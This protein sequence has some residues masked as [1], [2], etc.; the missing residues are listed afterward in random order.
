V[1]R[2]VIV[3]VALL[4]IAVVLAGLNQAPSTNANTTSNAHSTTGSI[5]T[6]SP[7]APAWVM[8]DAIEKIDLDVNRWAKS[9]YGVVEVTFIINNKS[10]YDVKD[11]GLRCNYYAPSGTKVSST[12]WGVYEIFKARTKRTIKVAR[13]GI[14]NTQAKS[15]GC[16][17]YALKKA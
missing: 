16:S 11:I 10:E 4:G 7:P 12:D 13:M 6:T 17:I 5:Q 9:E 8:Q 3:L 14:V 2:A 1:I 15:M